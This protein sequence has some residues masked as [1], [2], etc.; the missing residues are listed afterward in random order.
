MQQNPKLTKMLVKRL[1]KKH[2]LEQSMTELTEEEKSE[3]REVI[4]E[5]QDRVDQF[6]SSGQINDESVEKE[7]K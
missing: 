4:Q 6:I 7:K 5:C 1:M 3:L 2:G